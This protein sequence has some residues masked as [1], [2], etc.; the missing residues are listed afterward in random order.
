MSMIYMMVAQW[1]TNAAL[2]IAALLSSLM[3]S[4]S[5]ERGTYL[6]YVY[7]LCTVIIPPYMERGGR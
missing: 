1:N 4:M 5:S 3:G 2:S 7:I 6:P